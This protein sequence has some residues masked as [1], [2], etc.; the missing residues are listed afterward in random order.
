ME[1]VL[2]KT[3]WGVNISGPGDWNEVFQQIKKDGYSCVEAIPLTYSSDPFL[4]QQLLKQN[5]ALGNLL[6]ISINFLLILQTYSSL[7]R[8]TQLEDIYKD[9]IMFT[10]HPPKSMTMFM[11]FECKSSKQLKWNQF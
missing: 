10:L 7:F 6:F 9:P 8:F 5:G 2:S 1:L 3:L 4:F 11:T